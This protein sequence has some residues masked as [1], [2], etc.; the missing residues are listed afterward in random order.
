MTNRLRRSSVSLLTAA[1]LGGL[2]VGCGGGNSASGKSSSTTRSHTPSTTS[3]A[4]STTSS[5]PTSATASSNATYAGAPSVPEEAKYK[6]DAGAI[7][8]A[9]H[10]LETVNKVGQQPKL[11]V[12]EHLALESCKTCVRQRKTVDTLLA[13]RAHY[14]G[15]QMVLKSAS[16][17]A[18][19]AAIVI[20]VRLDQPAISA[21]DET[22]AVI[23]SVAAKGLGSLAVTVSWQSGWRVAEIQNVA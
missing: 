21:V 10:Y 17:V 6:T 8:F 19:P 14:T 3:S 18:D 22:G 20:E 23:R 16:R 1:C 4:P 13:K 7:A 11:G 2:L 9:K 15:P 12:L 5:A